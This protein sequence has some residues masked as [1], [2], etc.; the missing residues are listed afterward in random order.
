MSA[1][2]C[3]MEVFKPGDHIIASD[4]LYGGSVR[5]F[6]NISQK[7]GLSFEFVDTSDLTRI[8]T[9]LKPETKAVLSYS[10]EKTSASI[11]GR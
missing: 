9:C 6:G 7:N 2:A 3:L 10:R 5:Y 1:I 8:E 11:R 4:D